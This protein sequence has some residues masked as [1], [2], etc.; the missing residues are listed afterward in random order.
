MGHSFSVVTKSLTYFQQRV[1]NCC[2]CCKIETTIQNIFLL[3]PDTLNKPLDICDYRNC[4]FLIIRENL[5]YGD[6]PNKV[7]PWILPPITIRKQG[8]NLIFKG[9]PETQNVRH[10]GSRYYTGLY[11]W[12][13]F[14]LPEEFCTDCLGLVSLVFS[15]P[16]P[17]T[18]MIAP[19]QPLGKG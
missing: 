1:E 16:V 5:P 11:N 8:I 17:F 15:P 4:T 10:L 9:R 7:E 2:F 12:T 13:F 19:E 3:I 6:N 18:S 14:I